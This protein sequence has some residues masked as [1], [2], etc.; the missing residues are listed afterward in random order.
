MKRETGHGLHSVLK[1][2]LESLLVLELYIYL[3][4]HLSRLMIGPFRTWYN[5]LDPKRRLFYRIYGS[6]LVLST[7]TVLGFMRVHYVS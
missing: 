6:S 4:T 3:L 7:M 5:A 1:F 2:A